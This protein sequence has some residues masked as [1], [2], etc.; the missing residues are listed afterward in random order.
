MEL[1]LQLG[2]ENIIKKLDSKAHKK[3]EIEK[4]LKPKKIKNHTLFKTEIELAV[5]NDKKSLNRKTLC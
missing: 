4:C 2:N 5:K 1:K 3:I